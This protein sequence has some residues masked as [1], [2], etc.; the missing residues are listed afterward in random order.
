MARTILGK[1]NVQGLDHAYTLQGWLKGI[2]PAMGGS[3]TN[4]TDTTEAKPV[5]QDVFGPILGTTKVYNYKYDQ[6]NRLVIMDMFNGLNPSA[7]SFT[8]SLSPD[9]RG[10]SRYDPHGNILTCQRNADATRSGMDNLTYSYKPNTNQ[11]HKV[12]DITADANAANYP[13]YNDIR[14]GQLDNNYVYD[15]NGNLIQDVKDTI[16]NITW[17]VYGKI[18]S[19]TQNAKVF[20]DKSMVMLAGLLGNRY[21]VGTCP[22]FPRNGT[23]VAKQ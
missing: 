14:T 5:A 18:E 2:N 11:V 19:I 21:I 4:G 15:A 3:L 10:R 7:G 22:V 8:A 12:V 20:R 9:Y 16:T 17:N 6:L 23:H 13:K 1:L